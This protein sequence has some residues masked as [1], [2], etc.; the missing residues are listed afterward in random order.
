MADNSGET[1]KAAAA[2]SITVKL[3]VPIQAHGEKVS[4]L[5]LRDPDL[6]VLEGVSIDVGERGVTI[7]F[8]Q[9]PAL[10]AAM[11][12]IPPSSA[13]TIKLRDLVVIGPKVFDFLG[14]SQLIGES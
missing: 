5:T 14:L 6:G 12:D 7:H 10:I 13:K 2:D 11:A 1:G 4:T 8:S 9:L 3:R